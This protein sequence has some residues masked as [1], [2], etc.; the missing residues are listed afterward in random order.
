MSD[1]LDLNL[2]DS[3]ITEV[4]LPPHAASVHRLDL[5]NNQ[6]R[7][8]DALRHF[9]SLAELVLDKNELESLEALP[10]IPHLSILWLNNN[11]LSDLNQTIDTISSR[12]PN[13]EYLS[14]MRN[15]AC[16][17]AYFSDGDVE[18][19]NRYR[20]FVISKLSK[21]KFLDSTPVTDDERKEA[22]LRGSMMRIAKPVQQVCQ[23]FWHEQFVSS[24]SIGCLLL[25]YSAI[26]CL[27][28]IFK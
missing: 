20:C 22:A 14:M 18:S 16:P 26:G 28:V 11:S 10:A 24:P 4:P 25:V 15:P 8:F 3:G 5:T 19:Y 6:L 23:S 9:S 12:C 7:S 1:E 21:L 27:A 13:L 17:D 2:S